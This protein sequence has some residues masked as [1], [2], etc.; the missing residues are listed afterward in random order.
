[1]S[2]CVKIGPHLQLTTDRQD[3]NTDRLVCLELLIHYLKVSIRVKILM[4][5]LIKGRT[6]YIYYLLL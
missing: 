3:V 5:K 6:L 2:E 4:Q 1:M